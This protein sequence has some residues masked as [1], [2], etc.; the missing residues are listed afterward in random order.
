MFMLLQRLFMPSRSK[1]QEC[2]EGG[3]DLRSNNKLTKVGKAEVCVCI[4]VENIN[5]ILLLLQLQ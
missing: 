1:I 3:H 5:K 4:N 2:N